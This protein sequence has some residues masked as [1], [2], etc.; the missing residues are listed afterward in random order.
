V[1]AAHHE[2]AQGQHEFDFEYSGALR[3]ADDR[4]IGRRALVHGRDPRPRASRELPGTL[5]EALDRLDADQVIRDALGDYVFRH[6]VEAKRAE[7]DEYRTQVSD[8]E[9]DRYLDQF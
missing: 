7:R 6:Y 4:A 8:W 1:E 5:G 2:V 9:V 3:T